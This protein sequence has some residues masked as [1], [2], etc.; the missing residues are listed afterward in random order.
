MY[1]SLAGQKRTM[2]TTNGI[3]K[4]IAHNIAKN[5]KNRQKSSA[6]TPI[7]DREIMSKIYRKKPFFWLFDLLRKNS[8]SCYDFIHG[9]IVSF[10]C[11]YFGER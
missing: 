8:L 7:S 2:H 1:I 6:G 10:I 5:G 4:E 9:A 3:K 11:F